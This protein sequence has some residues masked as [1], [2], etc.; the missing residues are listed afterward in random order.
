MTWATRRISRGVVRKVPANND[1]ISRRQYTAT[2][3]VALLSQ[4]IRVVPRALAADVGRAAW[5]VPIAAAPLILLYLLFIRALLRKKHEGYSL[6]M[7]FEDALGGFLGRLAVF[8][9]SLWLVF[10]C[11]FLLRN[12]AERFTS[13]VYPYSGTGCFVVTMGLLCLLAGMG[14]FKTVARC[15]MI[16]RPILLVFIFLTVFISLFSVDLN[17]LLP[18]SAAD[19]LPV[20]KST[21]RLLNLTGPVVYMGFLENRTH[22]SVR[23]RDY[24]PWIGLT[25]VIS[26]LLCVCCIGMYGARLTARATLPVF[27]LVRDLT[28]FGAVERVEPLIITAW[29]LTDFTLTATVLFI[30]TQNL[31]WCFGA[32]DS[33]RGFWSLSGGRWCIPL[34]AAAAI[35]AGLSIGGN[36]ISMDALSERIIPGINLA[37]IL[38]LM[39]LVFLI[40]RIRKK[41]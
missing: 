13:T 40:G 25:L 32:R 21:L 1:F 16:F 29:V 37:V 41:I 23:L 12:I 22:G 35:A 20:A 33:G 5:L 7:L 36:I 24:L 6:C 10:Y 31:R 18:V 19:A 11:G 4:L 8:L 17:C 34:C 30:A 15:A 26:V 3:F 2:L 39:P 38:I 28:V 9:I 27:L 14:R